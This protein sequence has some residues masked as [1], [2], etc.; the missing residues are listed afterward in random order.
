M[1][2]VERSPAPPESLAAGKSYSSRDVKDQLEADF[3]GKC[4]L[5]ERDVGSRFQVDHFRP[6]S[7]YPH[8]EH[9]WTNLFP[10]CEC[11]QHRLKW[12]GRSEKDAEDRPTGFPVDGMLDPTAHDVESRLEQFPEFAVAVTQTRLVF[13]PVDDADQAARNTAEELDHIHNRSETGHARQLRVDI[14]AYLNFV[15]SKLAEYYEAAL[16]G[17]EPRKSRV[18]SDLKNWTS[19]LAPYTGLVRGMIRKRYSPIAPEL[20]L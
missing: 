8:L 15:Q 6:Q 9:A 3:H 12:S 19:V 18:K 11:N 17:D 2:T 5:C 1:I 10:A 20:G 13:Q 4:Y 7:G 16:K 14:G